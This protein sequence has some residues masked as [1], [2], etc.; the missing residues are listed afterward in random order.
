MNRDQLIEHLRQRVELGDK[1]LY[2]DT[3]TAADFIR[4]LKRRDSEPA[5]KSE[6]NPL[7]VI[8]KQAA[9]CT[10]CVLHATRTQ[11]VF[12]RGNPLSQLMVV[13]EAPGEEEDKTGLPFVGRAGKL[14]DVLLASI[15][16]PRDAA[17]IC[18]VL[19]CRPPNNRNP[20]PNEV[21]SC[22]GFLR[23][24]IEIVAPKAILAVGKFAAQTL[25][26]SEASIG[27]LRGQIHNYHGVPVVVT[28]HPAYLLR[29]PSATRVAWHDFQLLRTIVD[30][31]P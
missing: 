23:R 6:R 4:A 26:Q 19:K 27:R 13:G 11:S 10:A 31:Q 1:E 7:T 2:L 28:Y 15:G 16:F 3:M 9:A 14:L 12:A 21:E 24:Q 17:Y 30:E 25:V 5:V 8:E 22:S 18:N 20:L 29:S